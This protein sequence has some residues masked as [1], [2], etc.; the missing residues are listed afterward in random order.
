M[1]LYEREVKV[2]QSCLTLCDPMDYSLPGSSVHDIPQA[3]IL[4]WAAILFF[5][6]SS[7]HRTWTQV[8]YIAS[9]FFTI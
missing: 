6:G 4:E 8:F 7:Q 1:Q 5:K 3:R 9:G 2:T